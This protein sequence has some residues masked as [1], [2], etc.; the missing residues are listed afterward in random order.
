M[1]FLSLAIPP[2]DPYTTLRGTTQGRATRNDLRPS[3]P[4]EIG[5]EYGRHSPRSNTNG[6]A[7]CAPTLPTV[8][9]ITKAA[10]RCDREGGGG[11]GVSGGLPGPGVGGAALL[12]C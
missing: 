9:S 4:I 5:F 8:A 10:Q 6:C 11:A 7:P 3:S 2:N 1:A 12:T